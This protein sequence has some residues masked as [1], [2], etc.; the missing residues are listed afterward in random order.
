MEGM[1]FTMFLANSDQETIQTIQ[2]GPYCPYEIFI[3]FQQRL[4]L[5][6]I[7]DAFKKLN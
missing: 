1:N 5:F 7:S 3:K 4:I 6:S 2:F